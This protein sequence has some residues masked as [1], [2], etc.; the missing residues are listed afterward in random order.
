MNAYKFFQYAGELFTISF[1]SFDEESIKLLKSR[2]ANL[3]DLKRLKE[4]IQNNS[5]KKDPILKF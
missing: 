1:S 4:I 2:N 3:D 5:N